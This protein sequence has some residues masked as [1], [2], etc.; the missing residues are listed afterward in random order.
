MPVVERGSR[1][2]CAQ[3]P[4]YGGRL[5]SGGRR[6]SCTGATLEVRGAW[7]LIGRTAA[8][9]CRSSGA[10]PASGLIRDAHRSHGRSSAV[11]SP[12]GRDDTGQSPGPG[13]DR[14]RRSDD[15]GGGAGHP[16]P[17]PARRGG[18]RGGRRARGHRAHPCAPAG[19][20]PAG[21]PD[22]WPGRAHGSGAAPPGISG[23]GCDHADDL[24]SGRVRHPRPGGGR[25][26]LPAEG[27]RSERTPQ[28]RTGGGSRRGLPV[29]AGRRP[30]SSRGCAHT[31]RHTPTAP[32]SGSRNWRRRCW[33][34]WGRACPTRR[35]RACCTSSRAR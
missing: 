3:W 33:P 1:R 4:A 15:P 13:A 26:R 21:H 11:G 30:G 10:R 14:R 19:R 16:R 22:A 29:P 6:D 7:R 9:S 2:R 32:W 5:R 25:R 35:S 24:R 12:R 27:G 23:G 31:G 18:R 28:R 8:A 20:G 17:G 34:D